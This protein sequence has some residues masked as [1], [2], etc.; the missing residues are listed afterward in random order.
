MGE[1]VAKLRAA[2]LDGARRHRGE[3]VNTALYL[4]EVSVLGGSEVVMNYRLTE[5]AGSD[6]EAVD[7]DADW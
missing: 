3:R 4:L 1:L 2:L 7:D 6:H 5:W